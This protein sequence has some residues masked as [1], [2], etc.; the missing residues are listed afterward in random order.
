[1][2]KDSPNPYSIA[3][4]R[5]F[6]R[7]GVTEKYDQVN[8]D[9]YKKKFLINQN[10]KIATAG[11]CFAQHIGKR[12]R[13]K[14]F[15]VLDYE[16]PYWSIPYDKRS[17]Y[18]YAIY[19]ARYG[20]IYSVRQLLQLAKEAFEITVPKDVIWK[21]KEGKFVDALRP[22][23]YPHGFDS[24][25]EVLF[26]RKYHLSKVRA[27]FQDMNILIFTLG[28]TEAWR[29][30]ESGTVFPMIPG[31]I[32]G[33]FDPNLYEFVNFTYEEI[34]SDLIE[35]MQILDQSDP[36]N[37]LFTVSPVPL[38]ATATNN[39]VLVATMHSK[40]ILRAVVG[41]IYN[42]Y[43]NV[44]YFPSYEIVVNPWSKSKKYEDNQRSVLSTAVDEVMQIFLS[45][46]NSE[47][48]LDKA[49]VGGAET[50]SSLEKIQQFSNDVVCEEILL[51]LLNRGLE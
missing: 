48:V 51:D 36:K 37:Y 16:P 7:T 1:M 28:L 47:F 26:F 30:K 21:N 11:S 2:T 27:L 43:S 14:G 12:L 46:H 22:G 6:W 41:E 44:D 31:V 23:V 3:P 17:V 25:E 50:S 45:Q 24:P 39:H 13:D 20:N 8:F 9:I 38:T 35:L 34:K 19:S 4:P 10:S 42:N 18:G 5:S 40:S 29:H 33:E 15:N 49:I 32:A